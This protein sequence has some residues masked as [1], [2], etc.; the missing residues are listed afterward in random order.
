VAVHE[1]G[2]MLGLDDEYEDP[3]KPGSA[4][5]SALVRQLFGYDV[6]RLPQ[7]PTRTDTFK[8]SVMY[9]GG[10]GNVLAEH[11]VVFADAISQITG[12]SILDWK[13]QLK[14]W[15]HRLH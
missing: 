11:G 13:P 8:D 6:P 15:P 7:T 1:F 12:T 3:G 5:H 10:K 14:D 2:H 4:T 9:A